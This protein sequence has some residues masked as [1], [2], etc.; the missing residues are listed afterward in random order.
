MANIQRGEASFTT[1][2]GVKYHIVLDFAAFVEASSAAKMNIADFMKALQP[3]VD[4]KTGEVVDEPGVLKHLSALLFGGLTERHPD[5]TQRQAL[6]LLA[7]GEIVGQ[8]LGKALEA[9]MPKP[10]PSA[11]GKAPA[12]R[13]TGTKPKRTGQRRA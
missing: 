4:P 8:T 2:A 9:A 10:D 12:S 1:A 11:E 13:G 7:E 5:I 6:N 3:E